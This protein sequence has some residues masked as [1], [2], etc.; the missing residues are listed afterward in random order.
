[1]AFAEANRK[2]VFGRDTKVSLRM[3][4]PE[5]SIDN[6]MV[7][8][9]RTTKELE[10]VLTDADVYV[11][12]RNPISKERNLTTYMEHGQVVNYTFE[13]EK[14]LAKKLNLPIIIVGED[15]SSARYKRGSQG[16][17]EDWA[18]EANLRVM[19]LRELIIDNYGDPE[20]LVKMVAYGIHTGFNERIEAT[21]EEI[22]KGK[23]KPLKQQY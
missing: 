10:S 4:G 5:G 2:E 1:M 18:H 9:Q 21:R 7:H 15:P 20:H 23:V 13:G 17:I 11:A 6:E 14:G 16:H 22:A 3:L 12:F 19:V 8:G